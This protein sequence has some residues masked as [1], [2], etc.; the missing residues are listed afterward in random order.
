MA[1]NK[2]QVYG[3]KPDV[4]NV[5]PT[6]D[7]ASSDYAKLFAQGIEPDTLAKA[8]DVLTPL[9]ELT[10]FSVSF[11]NWLVEQGLD[12]SITDFK[13]AIVDP[14]D[15][16]VT[17]QNLENCLLNIK[18]ALTQAIT[19][20]IS[21]KEP[22]IPNKP[23]PSSFLKYG[24]GAWSWDANTYQIAYTILT[25]INSYFTTSANK[26][27][28]YKKAGDSNLKSTQLP[29]VYFVSETQDANSNYVLNLATFNYTDN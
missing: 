1:N 13:D 7:S 12:A 11:F 25:S 27:F 19:N 26:G 23:T 24:N 5:F 22:L 15:E 4:N 2:F 20:K 9:R 14:S 28:M 21:S 6:S 17:V 16:S 3:Q 8:Q 29:F 18:N 10:I